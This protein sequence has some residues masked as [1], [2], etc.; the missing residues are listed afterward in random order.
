MG[1]NVVYFTAAAQRPPK[2]I[3]FDFYYMHCVNASIF[4]RAFISASW[5]SPQNKARLLEMKGRTDLA[6][7]ASRRA[8]ALLVDDIR[9][10]NI[11]E[12]LLGLKQGDVWPQ[13]FQKVCAMK[14]D[15]HAS[16]FLRSI[17]SAREVSRKFEGDRGFRIQGDDWDKLGKMGKLL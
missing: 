14:D 4:F 13:L 9:N 10:Y 6:L 12:D 3:K 1:Q 17:A 8:P 5:L 2:E 11:N 15:G 16:K 7:Y